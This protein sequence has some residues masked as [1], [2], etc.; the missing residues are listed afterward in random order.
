M[1]QRLENVHG[2]HLCAAVFGG[3]L[4]SDGLYEEEVV[5]LMVQADAE[6]SQSGRSYEEMQAILL[7]RQLESKWGS[8]RA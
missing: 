3:L 8:Q 2:Q 4:R 1:L 5:N 6:H 7:P